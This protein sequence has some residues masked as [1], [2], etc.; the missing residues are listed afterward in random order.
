MT[1]QGRRSTDQGRHVRVAADD[2]V[3]RHK[4]GRHDLIRERDEVASEVADAVGMALPFGLLPGDPDVGARCVHVDRGGGP[5]P[6]ELVVDRTHAAADVEDGLPV[7]PARG[8]RLDQRA[9]Q[10]HG[11]LLTVGSKM[12]GR[13]AGVELAIEGRVAGCAAVHCGGS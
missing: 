8:E 11:A 7:D 10:A 9:S 13:V 1:R 3:K 12:L 2:P 4:V 6:Q 5:G